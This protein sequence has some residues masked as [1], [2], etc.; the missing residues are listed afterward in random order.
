MAP[1][2]SAGPATD[3]SGKNDLE[4]ER[5][6]GRRLKDEGNKSQIMTIFCFSTQVIDSKLRLVSIFCDAVGTH[7]HACVVDEVVKTLLS[8]RERWWWRWRGVIKQNMSHQPSHLDQ[9]PEH[10]RVTHYCRC[11]RQTG[12]WIWCRPDPVACRRPWRPSPHA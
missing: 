4:G 11:S 2:V 9:H 6:D 8:W 5:E 10:L 1:S 3:R 7:G 12:R